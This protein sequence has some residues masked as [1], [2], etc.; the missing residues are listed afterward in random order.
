MS[1]AVHPSGEFVYLPTLSSTV[2]A[3]RVNRKT[4]QLTPIPGSPFATGGGQAAFVAVHPGGKFV[5]VA[6]LS[7]N[8]S[9][10]TVDRSTGVLTP[11][12]GSP[13]PAGIEPIC[14]AFHPNGKFL[15]VVNFQ[16]DNVSGFTMDPVTGALT[17]IAGSPF[18]TGSIPRSMAVDPNG[19]FA[20]V[21]NENDND[22]SGYEVDPATGALTRLATSPFPAGTFPFSVAVDPRGRFVYAANA[23]SSGPATGSVSAYTIDRDTGGLTAVAGSPFAT[24]VFPDFVAVDPSGRFV[25]VANGAFPLPGNISGYTIDHSTGALTPIADSPFPAGTFPISIAI[26]SCARSDRIRHDDENDGQNGE[27]DYGEHFCRAVDDGDMR[28]P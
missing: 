20:Y 18:A 3:Y 16:G 10:Y 26:T 14:I 8:V 17:A 23:T 11:I 28:E 22:I 6:N 1:V 13:F 5:Y 15:Y 21:A 19:R 2:S 9:G 7:D 12:P 4:G 27:H 25:Y 24:G